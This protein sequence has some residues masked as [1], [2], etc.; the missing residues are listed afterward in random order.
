VGLLPGT[1]I[2]TPYG[3]AA[4]GSDGNPVITFASPEH[5]ARYR[6]DEANYGKQFGPT[7]FAGMPGAPQPEIKL[8]RTYYNPFSGAFLTPPN[9]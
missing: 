2:S 1:P 5:E 6:N 3:H 9:G 7:P 8:G 4:L